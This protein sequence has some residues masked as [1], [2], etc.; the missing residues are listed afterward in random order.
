MKNLKVDNQLLTYL[1]K[2]S[3]D[4]KAII[5]ELNYNNYV[6]F[7]KNIYHKYQTNIV[8]FYLFFKHN[9]SIYKNSINKNKT[10]VFK[11]KSFFICNKPYYILLNLLLYTF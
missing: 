3:I 6:Y 10:L 9:K 5:K 4:L 11:A 8:K 7:F 1:Y 2:L